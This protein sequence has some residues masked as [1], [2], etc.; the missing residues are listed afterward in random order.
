MVSFSFYDD[1]PNMAIIPNLAVTAN[2]TSLRQFT[3]A[4]LQLGYGEDWIPQLFNKSFKHLHSETTQSDIRNKS[5]RAML[6]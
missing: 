2:V 6:Q 1:T 4:S 3:Q 5:G